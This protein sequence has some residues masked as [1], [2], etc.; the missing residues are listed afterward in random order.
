[1]TGLVAGDPR[2]CRIE[3]HR[4]FH[5]KVLMDSEPDPRSTV[6]SIAPN[7]RPRSCERTYV[8]R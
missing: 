5:S 1:M 2:I 6:G 8:V 7:S 3:L 4:V